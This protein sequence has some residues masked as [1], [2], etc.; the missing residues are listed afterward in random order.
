MRDQNVPRPDTD[1]AHEFDRRQLLQLA[2]AAGIGA[3]VG[4]ASTARGQEISEQGDEPCR[5]TGPVYAP[6]DI[7]EDMLSQFVAVSQTLTGEKGLPHGLAAQYLE[8]FAWL[9]DPDGPADAT[10]AGYL[11]RLKALLEKHQAGAAVPTDELA[12]QLVSD[13]IVGEAAQ[14][15]IYLWYVSA[16]FMQSPDPKNPGIFGPGKNWLYGTT[17]QY[18][19]GLLWK[20]VKAH[21]PMMPGGSSRPAYWASAPRPTA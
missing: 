9:W 1:R 18:E 3:A 12:A 6:A 13:P 7:T 17:R 16:F 14:Q 19:Q 5:I 21:A 20:L 4:T 8:R 10:N 2:A 15:V 11:P